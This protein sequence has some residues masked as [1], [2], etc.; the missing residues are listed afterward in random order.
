M[1][2]RGPGRSPLRQTNLARSGQCLGNDRERFSPSGTHCMS[3]KRLTKYTNFHHRRNNG[4]SRP[5]G[6][7]RQRPNIVIDYLGDLFR[8]LHTGP[9]VQIE[10]QHPIDAHKAIVRL[11]AP[12][13]IIDPIQRD[14]PRNVF[15][16]FWALCAFAQ[17]F[18]SLHSNAHERH[19][20][21]R[22]RQ[23][24]SSN[25]LG[26]SELFRDGGSGSLELEFRRLSTDVAIV[27]V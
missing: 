5:L 15:G 23:C 27:A 6:R 14:A 12:S 22:P 9:V 18:R 20:E 10:A 21:L 26:Q 13:Y 16:I 24:P 3:K 7:N 11:G 4:L 1:R 8:S 25:G 19:S 17:A 2:Y